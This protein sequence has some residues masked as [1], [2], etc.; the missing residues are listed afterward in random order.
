MSEQIYEC[1]AQ[2]MKILDHLEKEKEENPTQVKSGN[3]EVLL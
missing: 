3:L 1:E 2:V